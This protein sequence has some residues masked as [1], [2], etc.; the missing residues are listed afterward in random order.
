[1][2]YIKGYRYELHCIS[3][4]QRTP[5]CTVWIQVDDAIAHQWNASRDPENK[6]SDTLLVELRKRYEAP[7]E[8]HR[9]DY[10]LFVVNRFDY[11]THILI[12][13]G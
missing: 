13:F 7:N 11:S 10:P 5:Q 12:Y 1:M 3:R 9:W 2:N 4:T 6:I 8:K